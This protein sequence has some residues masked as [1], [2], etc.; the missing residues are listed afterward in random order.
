MAQTA[1]FKQGQVVGIYNYQ[2]SRII[3]EVD[4]IIWTGKTWR[5]TFLNCK[6][7]QPIFSTYNGRSFSYWQ[8]ERW[9]C[10]W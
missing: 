7:K 10:A 6:T 1:K 9:L 8:E 3:Y 5:Y 4:K 2:G